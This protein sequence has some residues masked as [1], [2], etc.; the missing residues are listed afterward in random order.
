MMNK[1][2]RVCVVCGRK[3]MFTGEGRIIDGTWVSDILI[4]EE[5][6]NK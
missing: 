1:T 5:Y 3:Q 4:P 6:R 2:K